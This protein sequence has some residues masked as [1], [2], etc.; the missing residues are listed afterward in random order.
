MLF[1]IMLFIWATKGVIQN[2]TTLNLLT[3]L[4]WHMPLA[5]KTER[6]RKNNPSDTIIIEPQWLN[7]SGTII[8]PHLS[9][10]T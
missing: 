6:H 8:I 3:K 2:R 10:N 1:F 5:I 9:F 4:L 7:L